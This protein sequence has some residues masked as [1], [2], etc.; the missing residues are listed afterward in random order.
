LHTV[1]KI[2]GSEADIVFLSM[3]KTC[4]AYSYSNHRGGNLGF[5]DNPN[6]LNVALTRAK[7]QLVIIGQ[8]RNFQDQD[9]SEHLLNLTSAVTIENPDSNTRQKNPRE[10]QKDVRKYRNTPNNKKSSNFISKASE[11]VNQNA[12]NHQNRRRYYNKIQT[13]PRPFNNQ[14]GKNPYNNN[15]KEN[16][17]NR[18]KPTK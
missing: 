1:D 16:Y 13:N 7:Y 8:I 15:R 5:M 11:K 12:A 18:P 17:S 10:W 6:R 9:V 3:V 14:H 2:Q 4:G